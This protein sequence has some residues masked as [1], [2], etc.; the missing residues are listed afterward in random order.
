MQEVAWV[1]SLCQV[2]CGVVI[3][4]W[5]HG[6]LKFRWP[7]LAERWLEARRFSWANLSV[8]LGVNVFVLLPGAA[9]YLFFCA[10]LAVDHFSDGFLALRPG[11]LTVEV[12]KYVRDDGSTIQ[13]IPM[14]HVAE[15]DFYQQLSQSFPTN[16]TVLM[17]GVTDDQNLLTNR[18]SYKRMATSLGLAEQTEEFQPA[19]GKWVHADVDVEQFTTNTIGLLNLAMLIH[20][21]GLDLETAVKVLQYEPPPDSE[22]ELL[23]D[24][25]R[26]RNRHLLE[27]IHARLSE[28]ANI[29]VPWGAAHMPEIAREIQ[30]SGFRLD[31][32]RE[33]VVIRFRRDRGD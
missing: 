21:K 20:T 2:I 8:F 16:A 5:I 4:G 6:G 27:Q 30:K 29:I 32:T 12:R 25:L 24:L 1:I 31:E 3:L 11:G 19:R 9:G 10:A 33:Y 23:E 22:E 17:E 13:L 7:L 14:S 15:A 26:K 18:I 28:P